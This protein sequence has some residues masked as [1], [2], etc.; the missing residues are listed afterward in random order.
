MTPDGILQQEKAEMKLGQV[1]QTRGARFQLTHSQ[2]PA[3]SKEVTSCSLDKGSQRF[4]DCSGLSWS[5]LVFHC[6]WAQ[7]LVHRR[8]DSNVCRVCRS[9]LS[10]TFRVL[11][12]VNNAIS[13]Q[14]AS[15]LV[16]SGPADKAEGPLVPVLA[17]STGQSA[18]KSDQLRQV[19]TML[20]RT[21]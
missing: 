11:S 9:I 10:E 14:F 15:I 19:I 6:L 7:L 4:T 17:R 16:W 18:R 21:F 12:V 20:T 1:S 2:G 8:A 5:S 13:H 3:L